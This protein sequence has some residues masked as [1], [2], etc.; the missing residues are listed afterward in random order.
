MVSTDETQRCAALV[1]FFHRK[2]FS[3]MNLHSSSRSGSSGVCVRRAELSRMCHRGW[4]ESLFCLRVIHPRIEPAFA[5]TSESTALGL[6]DVVASAVQCDKVN[7]YNWVKQVDKARGKQGAL[8]EQW[9][10]ELTQVSS[11]SP[12]TRRSGDVQADANAVLSD[13]FFLLK[14][15]DPSLHL[16]KTVYTF[17]TLT[18][19]LTLS[20]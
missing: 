20:K 5:C 12:R 18:L 6:S 17:L 4:T 9:S 2:C 8:S 7:K 19:N 15:Y 3:V 1:V 16:K 13:F 10:R 11:V 14:R